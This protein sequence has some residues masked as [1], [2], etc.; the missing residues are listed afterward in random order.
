MGDSIYIQ[1]NSN[2][3][4][5]YEELVMKVREYERKIKD[6]ELIP[7]PCKIGDTVYW[8]DA[9]RNIYP[10]VVTDFSLSPVDEIGHVYLGSFNDGGLYLSKES[11]EAQVLASFTRKCERCYKCKLR[12]KRG[13]CNQTCRHE[14][15]REANKR[16]W[17]NDFCHG[18]TDLDME[19]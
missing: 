16:K 3:K 5:T 11:A 18:L 7:A 6:R 9:V 12:E 2:H 14:D 8:V 4:P 17:E 15:I 1:K 10:F 19:F 13:S